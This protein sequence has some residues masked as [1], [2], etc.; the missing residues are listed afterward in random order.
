MFGL[1]FVLAEAYEKDVGEVHSSM[2]V[3]VQRLKASSCL[4]MFPDCHLGMFDYVEP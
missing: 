3:G 1:F 4:H 2:L